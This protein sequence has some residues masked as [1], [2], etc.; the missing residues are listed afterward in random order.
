MKLFNGHAV[1]PRA[2]HEANHVV[3]TYVVIAQT[4]QEAR[5]RILATEPC[6]EFVT[7]PREVSDVLMTGV[8]SVTGRE[9]E[10]LRSACAWNESTRNDAYALQQLVERSDG[11]NGSE[12]QR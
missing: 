4:W 8:A 2:R 7:V 11:A 10:E 5:A 6:L 12:K 3:K 9:L 1:L